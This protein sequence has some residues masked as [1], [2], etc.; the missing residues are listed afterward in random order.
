M[1]YADNYVLTVLRRVG[2]P[3][4]W[5]EDALQEVRIREWRSGAD[6]G[7]TALHNWAIDALR[8]TPGYK[9]RANR[10][11]DATDSLEVVIE[12]HVPLPNATAYPSDELMDAE[13][14]INALSLIRRDA[15]ALLASGLPPI[16]VGRRIGCRARLVSQ[17][18]RELREAV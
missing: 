10:F 15:F 1:T 6:A 18:Q 5:L 8:L 14:Q 9:R 17:Y 4:L 7:T 16:E 13:R 12:A 11:V 3:P 2:V